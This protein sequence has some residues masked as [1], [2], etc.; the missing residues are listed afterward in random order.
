MLNVVSSSFMGG[1]NDYT[2]NFSFTLR[3]Q[4]VNLESYDCNY[5]LDIDGVL[6]EKNSNVTQSCV[7]IIVGG[8][9][10]FMFE[11]ETRPPVNFFITDAQRVVIYRVIKEL[12]RKTDT[13]KIEANQETLKTF[14][15]SLYSNLCG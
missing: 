15:Q 8:I 12:S 11:K 7:V 3:N 13:A 5:I 1:F 6:Y 4:Q 2:F 10:T 14:I 9:D